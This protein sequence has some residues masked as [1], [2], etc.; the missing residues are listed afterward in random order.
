M[1][2]C[3]QIFVSDF[4]RLNIIVNLLLPEIIIWLRYLHLTLRQIVMLNYGYVFCSDN[5]D[6]KHSD[7][8]M[9]H[10]YP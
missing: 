1:C 10:L 3:V 6:L 7:S 2:V 9:K 8:F 5:E 4:A